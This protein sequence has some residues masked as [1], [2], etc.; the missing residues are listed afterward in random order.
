MQ[1]G[2]VIERKQLR[3]INLNEGLMKKL[4]KLLLRGAIKKTLIKGLKHI[5]DDPDMKAQLIDLQQAEER[6]ADALK[7][8]CK[9]H[10]D[11]Q[12][13]DPKSKFARSYGFK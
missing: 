3:Q 13:C 4:L 5:D 8:Y 12:L 9:R 10:P 11:S 2:K 7:S 6:A 1:K